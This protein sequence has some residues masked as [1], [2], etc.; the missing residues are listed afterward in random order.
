MD[1]CPSL[2]YR[3]LSKGSNK[4]FLLVKV[5]DQFLEE[6]ERIVQSG[7]EENPV[8]T[9]AE[10]GGPT[11][12]IE[13][14][15]RQAKG[16]GPFRFSYSNASIGKGSLEV[17]KQSADKDTLS[18]YTNIKKKLTVRNEL[19]NEYK[20][21]TKARTLEAE[22]DRKSAV[23]KLIDAGQINSH[24]AGKARPK[25]SGSRL[26][27]KSA[28]TRAERHLVFKNLNKNEQLL[29]GRISPLPSNNPIPLRTR[30]LHVLALA[31]MKKQDIISQLNI[32]E[33]KELQFI[34]QILASLAKLKDGKYWLLAKCFQEI[35]MAKASFSEAEKQIVRK[36]ALEA[37][38]SLNIAEDAP[39]RRQFL[40]EKELEKIRLKRKRHVCAE[41]SRGTPEPVVAKKNRNSIPVA[42]NI[43]GLNISS[44]GSSGRKSNL[45]SIE[46]KKPKKQ[47][48]LNSVEEKSSTA[49]RSSQKSGLSMG[50]GKNSSWKRSAQQSGSSK[51]MPPSGSDSK[52]DGGL[53]A[54]PLEKYGP[55]Q[56]R[57]QYNSFVERFEAVYGEYKQLANNLFQNQDVFKKLGQELKRNEKGSA[58]YD[59]VQKKIVDLYNSK[60]QEVSN[61]EFKYNRLHNELK[62]IKK[63]VKE[64]EANNPPQAK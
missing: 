36:R 64:Y 14:E 30:I 39:E 23:T 63:Y 17:L 5:T 44:K 33:E 45:S 62:Q 9:F 21:K 46:E 48:G 8:I 20:S 50:E 29:N 3:L 12:I 43:A 28:K 57:S 38:D 31:P 60:R 24:K 10:K 41:D 58:E 34:G 18:V 42:E 52:G 56:S 35:D 61:T 2:P 22:A 7:T 51:S 32:S 4:E 1:L 49:K 19:S 37:C 55:I 27:P 25:V 53:P 59:K 6:I 40:S 13:T 54:R 15:G 11:G 26:D 47:I 16:E